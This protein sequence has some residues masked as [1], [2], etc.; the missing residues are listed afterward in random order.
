MADVVPRDGPPPSAGGPIVTAVSPGARSGRFTAAS[1]LAASP[2]QP[3]DGY[4][5]RDELC[6]AGREAAS[7]AGCP[8]H[9]QSGQQHALPA[10]PV[11]QAAEGQQQRGED[12]VERVDD[13]LQLGGGGMKLAHQGRKRHVHQRGVQVDEERREQQRDQDHGF[14]SHVGNGTN[15]RCRGASPER[16]HAGGIFGAPPA[17]TAVPPVRRKHGGAGRDRLKGR[18]RDKAELACPGDGL[19]TVGRAELA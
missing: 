1:W 14:G 18:L 7:E 12:E 4:L 5:R 15:L 10:E 17:G 13:P 8:E 16:A 19:R 9:G 11:G 3:G 6:R 2:P